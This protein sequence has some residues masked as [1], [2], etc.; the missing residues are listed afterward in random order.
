MSIKVEQLD[1]ASLR[2]IFATMA[3]L[4]NLKGV[5]KESLLA[6][7]GSLSADEL[8]ALGVAAFID[9]SKLVSKDELATLVTQVAGIQSTVDDVAT[10]KQTVSTLQNTIT[11]LKEQVVALQNGNTGGGTVVPSDTWGSQTPTD[12]AT[13]AALAAEKA[14]TD[15]NWHGPNATQTSSDEWT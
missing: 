13:Q 9:V 1:L 10:L 6:A 3:D 12:S 7:L 15:D 2:K 4:R 8:T 14:E 5:N 11:V